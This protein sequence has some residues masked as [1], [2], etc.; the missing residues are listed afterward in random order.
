MIVRTNNMNEPINYFGNNYSQAA[1]YLKSNGNL[2]KKNPNF[3]NMPIINFSADKNEQIKKEN[4]GGPEQHKDPL[5]RLPLRLCAYTNEVGAALSPIPGIGATLFK[6]SWVPAL[7]YFGADIYDKYS[8]G[9]NN[10][11]SKPSGTKATQESIFQGLASVILPT[12]AVIFGQRV[13]SRASKYLS[14]DKID[15]RAKES[16]LNELQREINQDKLRSH[17]GEIDLLLKQ[18]PTASI[19]ELRKND[20]VKKLKS[21]LSAN[22]YQDIKIETQTLSEHKKR[23]NIFKKVFSMILGP[24]NEFEYLSRI[25]P[26]KFEAKVKP[27]LETQVDKLVDIRI[28]LQKAMNKDGSFNDYSKVLEKSLVKKAKKIVKK[29]MQNRDVVDK[30]NF[31]VKECVLG[32]IRQ[33]AMKLSAVK[34]VGGFVALGLLAKPIDNFVENIIVEKIVSPVL[35]KF[36]AKKNKK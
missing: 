24:K 12:A 34:I 31:A 14:K 19:E 1:V 27:Y 33:T 6:L 11:Y 36:E 8:K 21:D 9:E 13:V 5:M 35:E 22:I 29:N 26:D 4:T 15:V 32:N 30:N 23:M 2:K 7:L 16:I 20:S 18:N 3:G 17:R 10:D 28:K 25:S